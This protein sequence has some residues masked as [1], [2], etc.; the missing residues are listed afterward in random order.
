MCEIHTFRC[1]KPLCGRRWREYRNLASCES[2]GTGKFCDDDYCMFAGRPDKPLI[3]ECN[4]CRQLREVLEVMDPKAAKEMAKELE[5]A[6]AANGGSSTTTQTGQALAAAGIKICGSKKSR[7]KT[8]L[9]SSAMP[10]TRYPHAVRIVDLGTGIGPKPLPPGTKIVELS[11]PGED[12]TAVRALLEMRKQQQKAA[13]RLV[14]TVQVQAEDDDDGEE[15]EE[16]DSSDDSEDEENQENDPPEPATLQLL[17]NAIHVQYGNT[18]APLA[19]SAQAQS[20]GSGRRPAGRTSK[21][22]P[23][24]Q[25]QTAAPTRGVL[26]PHNNTG[27]EKIQRQSQ[28]PGQRNNAHPTRQNQ[29]ARLSQQAQR[30]L[31]PQQQNAGHQNPQ[32]AIGS[33][34]GM[35][36]PMAQTQSGGNGYGVRMNPGASQNQASTQQAQCRRVAHQLQEAQQ[37]PNQR[38]T[39]AQYHRIRQQQQQ[40]QMQQAMERVLQQ[41]VQIGMQQ[42]PSFNNNPTQGTMNTGVS[43]AHQ[44]QQYIQQSTQQTIPGQ[45]GGQSQCQLSNSG[46]I[47]TSQGIHSNSA[48]Q[49]GDAP[50]F[51]PTTAI[52]ALGNISGYNGG[53]HV[54]DVE[55]YDTPTPG[56]MVSTGTSLAIASA[57]PTP[58]GTAATSPTSGDFASVVPSKLRISELAALEQVPTSQQQPI[59]ANNTAGGERP[60]SSVSTEITQSQAKAA[61]TA[62]NIAVATAALGQ[63]PTEFAQES[64]SAIQG[65]ANA[66]SDVTPNVTQAIAPAVTT[67]AAQ[68]HIATAVP[69]T[70]Q[71]IMGRIIAD[72]G[73]PQN[74]VHPPTPAPVATID[75]RLLS[76]YISV[77]EAQQQLTQGQQ[78]Q[79]VQAQTEAEQQ[80]PVPALFHNQTMEYVPAQN[81]NLAQGQDQPVVESNNASNIGTNGNVGDGATTGNNGTGTGN[82]DSWDPSFD[83]TLD[84]DS[85]PATDEEINKIIAEMWAENPV[86]DQL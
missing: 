76:N 48:L 22:M 57:N 27:H 77:S 81:Q 84:F 34:M 55:M 86:Q 79:D 13:R 32:A 25:D 16:E 12:T 20:S 56:S 24:G 18:T 83:F 30:L 54:T 63:F 75:P 31:A 58:A 15:E 44:G 60:A 61:I 42:T 39:P 29:A 45:Q 23:R 72:V 65:T 5:E 33:G 21:G 11:G 19:T 26:A 47:Y 35:M 4:N 46:Y 9:P 51:P 80:P 73:Q 41:G 85:A 74:W 36:M 66:P 43:M 62:E 14:P 17:N 78:A 49:A 67:V 69:T 53:N 71:T 2:D 38:M 10:T 37:A 28:V 3:G 68:P 70:A 64:I 52:S 6:I 7:G 40:D 50:G 82:F 1:P 59:Q 8:K